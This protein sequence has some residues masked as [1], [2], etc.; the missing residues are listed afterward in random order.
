MT[1]GC[2]LPLPFSIRTLKTSKHTYLPGQT[3]S[4]VHLLVRIQN[5]AASSQNNTEGLENK[6]KII[7]WFY[8]S[9]LQC[10]MTRTE[11]K[12]TMR[13][14]EHTTMAISSKRAKKQ[15][16]HKSAPEDVWINEMCCS[17]ERETAHM[18]YN[19]DDLKNIVQSEMNHS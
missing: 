6:N 10:L 13:Y 17:L 5:Q 3:G 11:S 4:P 9:M 15:K 18:C 1:L 14:Q 7:L 2:S 19:T 8:S 16:Q 12:D